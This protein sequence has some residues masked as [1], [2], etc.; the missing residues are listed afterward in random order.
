MAFYKLISRLTPILKG[1][2]NLTMD[3][4]HVSDRH[5]MI[6][7]VP[8]IEKTSRDTVDGSE[9]WQTHQ[10]RLVVLSHYL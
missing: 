7:Q 6:P 5:G 1:E 10:L 2:K 8:G 3:I 9:I 4:N